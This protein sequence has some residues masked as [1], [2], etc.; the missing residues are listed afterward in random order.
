MSCFTTFKPVLLTLNPLIRQSL[1]KHYLEMTTVEYRDDDA[2]SSEL[3]TELS[4]NTE[5]IGKEVDTVVS[6]PPPSSSSTPLHAL[7]ESFSL[8]RKHLKGF[9]KRSNSQKAPSLACLVP[10]KRLALLPTTKCASTKLLF[11]VVFIS[12]SN[13]S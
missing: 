12:L 8:K 1:I 6:K 5:S 4:S 13:H 2:R 10:M 3:E 7:S 11:C 9:R